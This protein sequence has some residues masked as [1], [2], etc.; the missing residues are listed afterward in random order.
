MERNRTAEEGVP[1]RSSRCRI[2]RELPVPTTVKLW[3]PGCEAS[4]TYK[5]E[6]GVWQCGVLEKGS[7]IDCPSS[8]EAWIKKHTE[9]CNRGIRY[10]HWAP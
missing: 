5:S 7:L 1:I 6:R 4:I 9:K 3:C 2:R 8:V 10:S